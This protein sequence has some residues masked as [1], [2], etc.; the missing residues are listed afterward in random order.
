MAERLS[1]VDQV[2]RS[3]AHCDPPAMDV[4]VAVSGGPD[5]VALLRAVEEAITGDIV[6]MQICWRKLI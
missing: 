2:R 6:T 5:S 4:V 3:L 1:L